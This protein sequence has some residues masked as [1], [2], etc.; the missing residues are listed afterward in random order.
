MDAEDVAAVLGWDACFSPD[1][2]DAAHYAADR[3]LLA[4][5]D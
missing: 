2:T 4:L 5:H 3:T 1:M